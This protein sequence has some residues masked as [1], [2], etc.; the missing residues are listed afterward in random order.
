MSPVGSGQAQETTR[1]KC[2]NYKLSRTVIPVVVVEL[3]LVGD[4]GEV[5]F[6][7]AIFERPT[8]GIRLWTQRQISTSNSQH[9]HV[10]RKRAL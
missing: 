1:E 7:D 9:L 2:T 4:D 5:L 10:E 3:E 8:P 6:L